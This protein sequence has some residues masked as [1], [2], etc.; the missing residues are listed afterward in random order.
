MSDVNNPKPWF[1]PRVTG[2]GWTP[3]SWQGWLVTL[4][5]CA[6]IIATVQI[7][8]PQGGGAHEPFPW[9]AAARRT[10]G[11]GANGLGVIG[12]VA[13]MGLE[14]GAFLLVAW[15]TSRPMRPLN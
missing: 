9:A 10:L 5:F 6:L 13:V 2:T 14:V 1:R 12:A 4:T 15:W 11:L 7:V 8:I 3:V